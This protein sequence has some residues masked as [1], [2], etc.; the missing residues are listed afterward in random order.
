VAARDARPRPPGTRL[1]EARGIEIHG[2]TRSLDDHSLL[3][4]A[5]GDLAHH[6]ARGL[7]R[8][9]REQDAGTELLRLTAEGPPEL[10]TTVAP[11]GTVTRVEVAV[12]LALLLRDGAGH[13]WLM[14]G[15]GRFDDAGGVAFDV[16]STDSAPSTREQLKAVLYETI[17]AVG[18][19]GNDFLYSGWDDARDAFAELGPLRHALDDGCTDEAAL[20]T[21]FA[22]TGALQELAISSGWAD[23]YARLADRFDA[24]RA[25]DADPLQLEVVLDDGWTCVTCRAEAG[26]LLLRASAFRAEIQR[27]W[28]GGVLTRA[29]DPAAFHRLHIELLAPSLAG[30]HALDPAYV[31]FYWAERDMVFCV[32]HRGVP[33]G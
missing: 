24:I 4:W 5:G 31:P 23:E 25:A 13:R 7:L 29:L 28:G 16:H 22:P 12:A 32:R 19:D 6:V 33:D 11:D 17:T 2:F 3:A 18:R 21:L 30:L 9:F 14:R 20:A 26:T 10:Q 27:A 15:T 8:G 1:S